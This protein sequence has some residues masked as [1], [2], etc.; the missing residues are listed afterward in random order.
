MGMVALVVMA[1]GVA[2]PDTA[3]GVTALVAAEEARPGLVVAP[4]A[5]GH[6]AS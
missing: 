2:A 1:L 6:L 5:V 3:A 4:D